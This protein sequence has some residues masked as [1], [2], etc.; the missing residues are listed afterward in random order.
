MSL[1]TDIQDAIEADTSIQTYCSTEFSKPCKVF[2]GQDNHSP[3]S[4]AD[5]PCVV[6]TGKSLNNR[7]DRFD[8]VRVAIGVTVTNTSAPVVTGNKVNY[9]GFEQADALGLLVKNAILKIRIG[10]RI[11]LRLRTVPDIDF[12]L[13]GVEIEAEFESIVSSKGN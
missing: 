10:K 12:P 2:V 6:I 5:T 1:Y 13:F 11:V 9:T 3:P 8:N 7:D 4:E